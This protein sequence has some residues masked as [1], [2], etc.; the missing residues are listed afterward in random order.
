MS[1]CRPSVYFKGIQYF[2]YYNGKNWHFLLQSR[3][4]F[5]MAFT[6]SVRKF[7]LYCRKNCRAMLQEIP[8][9]I[10]PV[11]VFAM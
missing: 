4:E 9:F 3:A 7:S 5:P 11:L 2:I 10:L 6:L 1:V 8:T